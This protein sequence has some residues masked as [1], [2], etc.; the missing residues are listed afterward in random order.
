MEIIRFFVRNFYKVKFFNMIIKEM[1]LENRLKK[2]GYGLYF[3]NWI[4][5]KYVVIV[6]IKVI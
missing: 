1:N 2:N 6:K 3:W 5:C 4:K